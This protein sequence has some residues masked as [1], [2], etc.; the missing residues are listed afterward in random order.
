MDYKILQFSFN[1]QL[2]F[3]HACLAS[4]NVDSLWLQQLEKSERKFT[5]ITATSASSFSEWKISSVTVKTSKYFISS[6]L[7][8]MQAFQN[9][10]I[11]KN[12]LVQ[13]DTCSR[14][15]YYLMFILCLFLRSYRIHINVFNANLTLKD[16]HY[17]IYIWQQVEHQF[18]SSSSWSHY[19][20]CNCATPVF[21]N[22]HSGRGMDWLCFALLIILSLWAN[23]FA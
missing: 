1:Q 18:S 8:F 5:D 16:R 22:S 7:C 23:A 6:H 13:P 10:W 11:F 4:Q 9:T 19:G 21:W 17:W 12:S 15:E 3:G 20:L 14:Q 2:F